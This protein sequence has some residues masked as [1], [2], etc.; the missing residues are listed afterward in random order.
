[1]NRLL[2]LT[3]DI[4]HASNLDHTWILMNYERAERLLTRD[5]YNIQDTY[6]VFDHTNMQMMMS[7]AEVA[8]CPK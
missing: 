5:E 3:F 2:N 4:I 7:Q 8:P 6:G 1:M